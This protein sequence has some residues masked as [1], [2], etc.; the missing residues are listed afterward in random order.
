MP[1]AASSPLLQVRDA[2]KEYAG[3]T[4]VQDISFDLKTREIVGLIGPNGA[5][6]TTL[7]NLITGL[8]VPTH[9]TIHFEG[10]LLNGL[11]PHEISKKGIARTFQVMR[12]FASLSV[13]EN[14]AVGA[15]FGAGGRKR[16]TGAAFR[17][18][19]EVLEFVHLADRKADPADTLTIVGRKRL[20]LARALAQEPRLLLLD[21]VMA[22][23]RAAEMDDAIDLIMAINRLG[24][25][26]LIIEHVVKVIT[27]VC[28]RV[29]VLDYGK[30]IADGTPAEVTDNTG[31]IC[32]YLGTKRFRKK[33]KDTAS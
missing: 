20:E 28:D 11:R 14:V 31:V 26:I 18:A 12:P 6:K 2:T 19:E 5:G 23:L 22:G 15:M 7:L 10:K 25:T 24:I 3:V 4:A 17:K 16:S 32:A 9:G 29:I 1:D 27:S 33:K 8:D 13:L 30:K 21:E